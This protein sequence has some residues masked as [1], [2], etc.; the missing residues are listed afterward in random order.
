M[1]SLVNSI[2]TWLL[3]FIVFI[4]GLLCTQWGAYVARQRELKGIKDKESPG[5]TVVAA[6][7][8]LLAFMLG[9]TFS[10]TSERYAS[11]KALVVQQAQALNTCYLRTSFIPVKQQQESRRLLRGYLDVLVGTRNPAIIEANLHKL[12]TFNTQLWD[13]A[14]S[15]AG[16][17]IDSELRSL[18]IGSVN[19]VVEVFIERKT[20]ALVFRIHSTIWMVLFLLY[21]LGMFVVGTESSNP[22]TR[23]IYYVPIMCASIALVVALI[24]DMDA[25]NR[26][27]R[28]GAN[29][30]PLIDVQKMINQ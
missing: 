28:F 5:G 17:S 25:S 24:A 7:L 1:A 9:F 8:G 16:D 15:L 29:Q 2:P 27:G 6:M 20:V 23:R 30:Q 18:Y 10:T 14:A 4:V 3:F 11:R 19:D 22:K 13:L 12:E 26:I 21:I